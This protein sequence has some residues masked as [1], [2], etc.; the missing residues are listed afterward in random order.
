MFGFGKKKKKKQ[1]EMERALQ[2]EKKERQD[3]TDADADSNKDSRKKKT[4]VDKLVMGAILGV[5]IGSVVGMSFK[6]KKDQAENAE[7]SMDEKL[8]KPQRNHKS[9][10]PKSRLG[11]WAGRLFGKTKKGDK[12]SEEKETFRKIP[13]EID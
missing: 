12:S 5:A 1:E 10:A 6:A 11:K 7:E 3:M 9:P 2:G 8:P 4:R 13:H